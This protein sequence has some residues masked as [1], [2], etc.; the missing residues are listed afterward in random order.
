M[1]FASLSSGSSGNSTFLSSGSTKI[2]IDNGLSLRTLAERLRQ[3]G[4]NI[5]GL[6]ACVIGH[7]HGD[8]LS[9]VAKLTRER[10]RRGRIMPTYLSRPT[11]ELIDWDGLER[12][13]VAYFEAGKRFEIGDLQIFPISCAHDAVDPV[14]FVVTDR[15][16]AKAVVATDMGS[17]P[18]ALTLYAR[19]AGVILLESNHDTELLRQSAYPDV[20]KR[21]ISGECGHLSNA[22]VRVWIRRELD[23]AV[24]HLVLGHISRNTNEPRRV[25]EGAQEA[26]SSRGLT[27]CRLSLATHQAATPVIEL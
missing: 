5:E 2:I 7:E 25:L 6:T 1:K 19:G 15:A 27:D 17:I 18:E 3:I 12:P 20:V 23:P 22:A 26:L 9:G 14:A 8:H 13:P 24:R 10:I 16:G 21:R 4:E 11:A